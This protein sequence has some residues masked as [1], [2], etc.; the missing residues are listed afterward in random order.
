MYVDV[1]THLTHERFADDL[2]QVVHRAMTA[3]LS[4]IVV[5]G[6][7]PEHNQAVLRLASR[8]PVIKP[9]LGIYPVDAVH[10]MLPADFPL[11]T[12][13]FDVD[14][15]IAF[16]RA[17]AQAGQL[18]AIGECGLDGHWLDAS[19]FPEQER[20]FEALIGIAMDCDI[21]VII[22]TRKREARAM[23]ILAALGA[24]KVNFHCYGGRTKMACDAAEKWGW[25]F[26]IPTNAT[27]NEAF[28]KMLRLL[29]LERIL[30]ETDAPYLAPRRGERNEPANV[31]GTID[32]LAK[33]RG[34]ELSV[35][36]AQVQANY[37]ELFG[38]RWV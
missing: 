5:N 29:P 4:A 31:V 3:G 22:H 11:E 10:P 7:N 13:S 14:Q 37:R 36:A 16:I 28:Q 19:T 35:A 9:A 34:L 2:D 33:I 21:P 6:L 24:R 15:E 18:A 30:T 25:W 17:A 26:S 8:Y 23:E 32:L 1:H 27:V 12:P 38:E 20:V